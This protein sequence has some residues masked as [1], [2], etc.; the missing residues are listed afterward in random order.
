[1]QWRWRLFAVLVGVNQGAVTLT[2]ALASSIVG[3]G[4]A[5][6]ES[7]VLF[8]SYTVSALVVAVPV[9]RGMGPKWC[10]CASLSAQCAYVGAYFI[11][12]ASPAAIS[13][14]LLGSAIGG[15]ASGCLW[16]AQGTYFALFAKAHAQEADIR[17]DHATAT[18]ASQFA[19]TFLSVEVAVKLASFATLLLPEPTTANSTSIANT[20]STREPTG[21]APWPTQMLLASLT[22][23]T[24]MCGLLAAGLLVELRPPTDGASSGAPLASSLGVDS[25]IA[26]VRRRS[27]RD[28]LGRLGAA[29]ALVREPQ[30]LYLAP[31][32]LCF[33]CSSSLLTNYVDAAIA[34]PVVRR[35]N[36][37]YSARHMLTHLSPI[38]R[39]SWA[40]SPSLPLRR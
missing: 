27:W 35:P 13:V 10:I 7:G 26:D 9:V 4:Y 39:R 3:V 14:A 28:Y 5:G 20:S 34:K 40:W 17:P 22:V 19:T 23:L 32:N 2:L 8:A 25:Q 38:L 29:A 12:S 6:T 21:G 1:M 24:G 30:A 15:L 37:L 18:L 16:A 36:L 31:F 33:A 11:A